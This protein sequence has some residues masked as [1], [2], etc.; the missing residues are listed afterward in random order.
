MPAFQQEVLRL[1]TLYGDVRL[2]QEEDAPV[3]QPFLML[4]EDF[5][6]TC[7]QTLPDAKELLRTHP[8]QKDPL[9]DKGVFGFYENNQLYGLVDLV[10]DYPQNGTWTIGYLL[11]HPDHQRAHKST[12]LVR[13]LESLTSAGMRILRCIVQKENHRALS[14]WQRSGFIPVPTSHTDIT[15][16]KKPMPLP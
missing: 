11:V 3:L 2:L 4:F 7:E 1:L 10:K 16:C 6:W 15:V 12:S 8:P 13:A 5:F 14:F 9:L